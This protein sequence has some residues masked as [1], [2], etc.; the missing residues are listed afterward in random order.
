VRELLI[1]LRR[2]FEFIE[3]FNA[4]PAVSELARVLI[5]VDV[6]TCALRLPL[7]SRAR[8]FKYS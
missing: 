5:N 1:A 7:K 8:Q 4:L 2:F 6:R 3:D